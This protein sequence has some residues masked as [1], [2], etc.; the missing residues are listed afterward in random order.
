VFNKYYVDEAYNAIFVRP[1][2]ALA[3]GLWRYL[4]AL[5]IDGAVNGSAS[6]VEMGSRALRRLQS[7]HLQNYA[8]SVALG[9]VA[10][11]LFWLTR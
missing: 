2:V 7:G 5:V 11:L 9:A 6:A 8:L 10:V 3:A 4:D 1:T